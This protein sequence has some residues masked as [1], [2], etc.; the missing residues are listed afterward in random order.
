[1]AEEE[2]TAGENFPFPERPSPKEKEGKEE[3][4][5]KVSIGENWVS[6]SL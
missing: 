5:E 3:K 4:L 1:M 2:A 6:V